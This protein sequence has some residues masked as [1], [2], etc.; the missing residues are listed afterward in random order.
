MNLNIPSYIIT[1]QGN[2]VSEALAKDCM[3]S[4]K[5]FG[6]SPEI[7]PAVHGNQ[8][9]S[10]WREH[11]LK[12]FKFNHRVK[13]LSKGTIGCLISHLILW[14]KSIEINKPILIFEH[15]AVVIRPIPSTITAKFTEICHLDRLS[16]ITTNYDEEVQVDRGEDVTI[17]LGK[18][19]P[20]SGL[21]LYN[22]TSIKGSHGY[23]IKPQ[24]AQRLLDWVWASGALS[25]D[26][27]INSIS[28]SL[29]YSNTSYCRINPK[30]WNSTKMKGTYSFCRP[31][32]EEKI[33]RKEVRNAF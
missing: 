15:D 10:A 1:M 18:R 27:V 22:K 33:K 31:T 29:T 8:V 2:T 25:P 26:V 3:D 11:N 30:Y 5:K 24:G 14:K 6:L 23:I 7:F 28:C 20:A 21:E 32:E 12:E 9:D 13:I 16:R 19:P 17:F 4:A